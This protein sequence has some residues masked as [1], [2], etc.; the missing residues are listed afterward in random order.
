M[1]KKAQ[2]YFWF[3]HTLVFS[4]FAEFSFSASGHKNW[5][6]SLAKYCME[7]GLHLRD[8]WIDIVDDAL[9]DY[10]YTK[11]AGVIVN[12]SLTKIWSILP[13]YHH[14]GVPILM[15]VGHIVFHDCETPPPRP[16]LYISLV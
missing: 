5:Q 6:E 1:E 8:Q 3:L 10:Q 7:K 13:R 2:G 11:W 15:E 16:Q 4:M 9:C 12:V 14:F